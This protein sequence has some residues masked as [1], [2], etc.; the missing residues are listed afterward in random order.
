MD[1]TLY[2][3][4]VLDYQ[5]TAA[6]P[7]GLTA[8]CPQAHCGISSPLPPDQPQGAQVNG[9]WLPVGIVVPVLRARLRLQGW[10]GKHGGQRR[11]GLSTGWK[12]QSGRAEKEEQTFPVSQ[13]TLLHYDNQPFIV[14]STHFGLPQGLSLSMDHSISVCP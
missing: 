1:R 7:L 3:D 13:K 5:E 11:R 12:L 9:R 4:G 14:S 6:L 2:F 8:G 10:R